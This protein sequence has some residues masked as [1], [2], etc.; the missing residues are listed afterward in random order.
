M[1]KDPEDK[2]FDKL[3]SEDEKK[4]A[5]EEAEKKEKEEA[6]LRQLKQSADI[7]ENRS[8]ALSPSS[9]NGVPLWLITFTDIM[10]LMLT[11]FVLL[12][13]MAVPE[14]DKWDEISSGFSRGF[15]VFKAPQS[16]GGH[17]DS[18]NIEKLDFTRA[19]DLNYLEA[20][21][22]ELVAENE[23]LKNVFVMHQHDS[24]ILSLPSDLLFLPSQT[25]VS[26]EGKKALF[27][28]GGPLSRIRNRIQIIG[29]TDPRPI[30]DAESEFRSNWEL[31]LAR[32]LSVSAVLKNAGYVRP[33][34]VRGLSSAR[35]DE[36]P[37]S[38]PEEERLD[39]ARRVD[40]VIMKDDGSRALLLQA[41]E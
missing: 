9:E 22:L 21:I 27:A 6:Y 16:F 31:S 13:S 8:S 1:D 26:I 17:R 12:Y 19:L 11:F 7:H 20:L 24:L 38:L 14:K 40:I 34:I 39:L 18:I 30:Q 5:D 10:A 37:E 2:D 35:Y 41:E 25:E 29:H 23:F 15:N 28:L 36:L 4:K 33:V 32:A 3:I